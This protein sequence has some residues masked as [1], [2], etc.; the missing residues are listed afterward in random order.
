MPI[1]VLLHVP[2]VITMELLILLLDTIVLNELCCITTSTDIL[3][4]LLLKVV[5]ICKEAGTKLADSV[6][7][8]LFTQV[9]KVSAILSQPLT[10]NCHYWRRCASV[11]VERNSSRWWKGSEPGTCYFN[12]PGGPPIK[13]WR[14]CSLWAVNCRL[15]SLLGCLRWKT[16]I[17]AHSGID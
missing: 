3:F 14:G 1:W 16:T 5:A 4:I 11:A 15:W 2:V 7:E 10:T 13:K 9:L 6:V 12:P 8:Q 17:F